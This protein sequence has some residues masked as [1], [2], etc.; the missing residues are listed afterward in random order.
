MW[1]TPPMINFLTFVALMV[2]MLHVLFVRIFRANIIWVRYRV[3][4][5]FFFLV[6]D[7][8]QRSLGANSIGIAYNDEGRIRSIVG[9][10]IF[11]AAICWSRSCQLSKCRSQSAS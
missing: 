6:L 7:V 11:Q 1:F 5:D 2:D 4:P 3:L 8:L 9:V 10:K